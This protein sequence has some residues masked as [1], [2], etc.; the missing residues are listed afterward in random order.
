[1][2]LKPGKPYWR[3][4]LSTNDLQVLTS[5][6]QLLFVMKLYLGQLQLTFVT[7]RL[8]YAVEFALQIITAFNSLCGL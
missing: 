7:L 2:Y 5:L 3:E 4:K 1:M 6:D 8:V